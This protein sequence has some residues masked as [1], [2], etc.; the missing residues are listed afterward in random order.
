LACNSDLVAVRA[1][2]PEARATLVNGV[3]AYVGATPAHAAG[4]TIVAGGK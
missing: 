4:W 3:Y 2:A 1:P